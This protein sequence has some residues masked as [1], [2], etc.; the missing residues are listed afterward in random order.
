MVV[1]VV[2]LP[3]STVGVM[4]A[5][6]EARDVLPPSGHRA[7]PRASPRYRGNAAPEA[8]KAARLISVRWIVLEFPEDT[9]RNRR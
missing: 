6:D 4:I 8:L 1:M 3:Y 7:L 2:S 5:P 9:A